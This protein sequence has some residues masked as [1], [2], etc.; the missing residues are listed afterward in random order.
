MKKIACCLFVLF[1]YVIKG[2]AASAVEF[3]VDLPVNSKYMWRGLE[4]NEDPVFQP[5][6]WVSYKG[7]SL[8]VWGNMELTGIY[9]GPGENGARGNFTEVDY[10]LK[11]ERSLDKFNYTA[12]YIYY[13]YPH[14]S[15][16]KTQEVFGSFGYDMAL[17]PTFTVYRDI[18]EAD[19]WYM[20][21]GVSHEVELKQPLNST[22]TLS[23]TLGFSSEKHTDFYYAKD[24]TTFTDAIFSAGLKIP[25]T[26]TL[27]IIPSAN[28]SAL[29]G[30]LRGEGL[31][32]RNDTFWYG[33]NVAFS[34]DTVALEKK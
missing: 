22:L 1:L 20:T 19:G 6:A 11:Y 25:I 34:F 21:W 28:Y 29:L 7:L 15:Y 10:I 4:L 3:G 16:R 14:T 27:A 32:K 30:S 8:T 5:D 26:D 23:G 12:G 33:I 18:D 13:D 2:G 24:A 17:N 31:N 9:N